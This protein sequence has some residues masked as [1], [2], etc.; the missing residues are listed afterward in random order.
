MRTTS[1]SLSFGLK[2]VA[3]FVLALVASAWLISQA[4]AQEVYFNQRTGE[5]LDTH[6]LEA[7]TRAGEQA[8]ADRSKPV[9]VDI[10]IF[11]FTHKE[12]AD[13]VLD[14][15]AENPNLHVRL[16]G[17]W[18]SMNAQDRYTARNVPSWKGVDGRT[19]KQN[20]YFSPSQ[21]RPPFLANVAAGKYHDACEI[22]VDAGGRVPAFRPVEP[23]KPVAPTDPGANATAAERA[24]YEEALEKYEADMET[25][26]VV[27]ER[28]ESDVQIK[29]KYAEEMQKCKDDLEQRFGGNP[30]PNLDIRFKIDEPYV[31]SAS[32]RYVTYS[33]AASKGLNHHKGM[34]VRAG[35]QP[36][37]LVSGSY[38]WSGTAEDSNYENL[39]VIDRDDVP[40]RDLMY[41]YAAEFDGFYFDT[42]VTL[43]L[44]DAKAFGGWL[45]DKVKY[46]AVGG[47]PPGPRPP[48]TPPSN[49]GFPIAPISGGC[50]PA[51]NPNCTLATGV[52]AAA[53]ALEPVNVNNSSADK[54]A[55]LFGLPSST[56]K[57]IYRERLANGPFTDMADFSSRTGVSVPEERAEFGSSKVYINEATLEDLQGI[58]GIGPS[59]AGK[60]LAQREK[61][62][63]FDTIDQLL[64]VSGIGSTTLERMKPYVDL[65]YSDVF[66]SSR[67]L[68][69]EAGIGYA[70]S[71]GE[72]TMLVRKPDSDEVE[73]VPGVLT[74]PVID[75]ARRAGDGDTLRIAAYG[76]SQRTDEFEEVVAAA[77]RGAKVQ[78]VLHKQYT[79]STV[80]AFKDIVQAES[81]DIEVRIPRKTMHEKFGF[82]GDDVFN[83][84]ANLSGSS[85]TKHSEDRFI[86]KNDPDL[87]KKFSDRFDQL[88]EDGRVRVEPISGAG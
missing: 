27:V 36:L 66:F 62:G 2:L 44:D 53:G 9:T 12:I 41:D 88:W 55:R 29:E 32:R 34:V 40:H 51:V 6:I 13:K 47:T 25:Y 18:T 50:D 7:M 86:F 33:H 60:I 59:L 75:I 61:Y 83:G 38:N 81:L 84:S 16:V 46:D 22:V 49:G 70:P 64:D 79:E 68:G 58:P 67:R 37:E 72:K 35:G 30:L 5:R 31:W 87:V 65:A 39:M 42:E 23:E 54:L 78:V 82:V 28:Y 48:R 77:R 24:E 73:R 56:A 4:F 1:T 19:R 74:Q 20:K 43:T 52:L 10:L 69:E 26:G 21:N 11:Q 17:D 80:E 71:N 14:I 8:A 76:F 63:E 3:A 45:R 57:G 15:I 85:S